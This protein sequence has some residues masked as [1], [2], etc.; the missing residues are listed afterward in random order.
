MK[1]SLAS[2][3]YI[4]I[5]RCIPRQTQWSKAA[6]ELFFQLRCLESWNAKY[7][8][9]A[10]KVKAVL[11]PK[12]PAGKITARNEQSLELLHKNQ[13]LRDEMPAL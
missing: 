8:D 6:T 5:V 3:P 7:W 2:T 10:N 12:R 11:S 4:I 13:R 1:T 9:L